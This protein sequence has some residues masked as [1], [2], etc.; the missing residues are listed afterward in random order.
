MNSVI[1]HIT[2]GVP[3]INNIGTPPVQQPTYGYKRVTWKEVSR[4]YQEQEVIN[5]DNKDQK[6]KIKTLS[7]VNW[8]ESTSGHQLT[9]QST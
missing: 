9:Y 5:P 4:N 8:I 6:I 3:V 2:I 7:Q 1:Q